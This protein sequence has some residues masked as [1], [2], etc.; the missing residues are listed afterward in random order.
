MEKII[1]IRDSSETSNRAESFLIENNLPYTVY[2]SEKKENLPV[3][4]SSYGYIPYEGEGGLNLFASS[5]S[6]LN[7]KTSN[8]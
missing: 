6:H 3:I 4:Y 7:V 8:E 2:Y 5:H 1:L